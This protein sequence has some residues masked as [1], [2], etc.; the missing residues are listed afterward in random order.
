[1]PS[2]AGRSVHATGACWRAHGR[3]RAREQVEP[4][5][6][7]R[8]HGVRQ[9]RER[10]DRHHR[11]TSTSGVTTRLTT[12]MAIALASGETSDTSPNNTSSSG[13]NPTVIA[14]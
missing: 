5:H 14:H 2:A 11:G 13:A 8:E 7:R 4:G 3:G 9:L 1:M 12:G 10:I 6:E